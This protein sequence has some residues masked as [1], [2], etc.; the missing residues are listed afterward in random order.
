MT[1]RIATLS[2]FALRSSAPPTARLF[3]PTTSAVPGPLR[4][5]LHQSPAPRLAAQVND[6]NE[7]KNPNED[8]KT[9]DVQPDTENILGG[10]AKGR[11]GGGEPLES[12][13]RNAPPK[14]KVDN[15]STPGADTNKELSE[16]QK[17]EVE[18]HNRDFEEKH[19]KGTRAPEDKVDKKFWA[20]TESRQ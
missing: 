2:R 19:D 8:R 10:S 5:N 18:E 1:Y 12:S 15:F 16:E 4:R 11:T 3:V 14:P 9:A 13:S 17:R 6:N 20:G 7:E